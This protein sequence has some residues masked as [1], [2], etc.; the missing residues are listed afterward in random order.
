MRHIPS[1]D[2]TDLPTCLCED[3]TKGWADVHPAIEYLPTRTSG[4]AL[5]HGYR[6]EECHSPLQ[7]THYQLSTDRIEDYTMSSP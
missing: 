7:Q 4:D 5:D 2:L 3:C 1:N 6:C